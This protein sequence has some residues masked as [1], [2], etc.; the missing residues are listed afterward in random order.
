M[1]VD[2]LTTGYSLK[3]D[4]RAHIVLKRYLQRNDSKLAKQ[5]WFL[6]RYSLPPLLFVCV[7]GIAQRYSSSQETLPLPRSSRRICASHSCAKAAIK[8]C[9][10]LSCSNS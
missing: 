9:V 7:L 1:A 2:E 4:H 8:K 10:P 6:H 5:N 3:A